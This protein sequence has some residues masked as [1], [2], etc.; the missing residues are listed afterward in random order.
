[1]LH[2]HHF[3]RWTVD[4][5]MTFSLC[6]GN[7]RG[8]FSISDQLPSISENS[9]SNKF[10]LIGVKS[11]TDSSTSQKEDGM[12]STMCFTAMPWTMLEWFGSECQIPLMAM[13][14]IGGSGWTSCDYF[15]RFQC[16]NLLEF[17]ARKAIGHD[18]DGC[19]SILA[20]LFEQF[21]AVLTLQNLNWLNNSKTLW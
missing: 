8:L 11:P 1:M 6:F 20:V 5:N 4:V 19:R 14:W 9:R 16:R 12:V 7:F 2:N 10:F 3:D 13:Q 17:D 15:A 21:M 18:I